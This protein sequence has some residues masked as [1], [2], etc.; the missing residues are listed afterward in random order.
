MPT[1]TVV[2]KV[3]I[4]YTI[5]GVTGPTQDV[6]ISQVTAMTKAAILALVPSPDIPGAETYVADVVE[7]AL[8]P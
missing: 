5:T 2:G 7:T 4:P 3:R 6:A 1:F 8:T